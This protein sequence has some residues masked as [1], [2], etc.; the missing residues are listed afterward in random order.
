[1]QF[2]GLENEPLL[3]KLQEFFGIASDMYVHFTPEFFG[4]EFFTQTP[5]ER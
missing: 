2:A 4:Q 3:A 5:G 1:V